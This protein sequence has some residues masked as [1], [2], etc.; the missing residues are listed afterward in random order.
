M[1]AAGDDFTLVSTNTLPHS[2]NKRHC[3]LQSSCR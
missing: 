3:P 2:T 1:Q